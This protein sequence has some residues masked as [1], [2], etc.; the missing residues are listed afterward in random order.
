VSFRGFFYTYFSSDIHHD[1]PP[2]RLSALFEF[3]ILLLHELTHTFA[4]FVENAWPERPCEPRWAF[5]DVWQEH[6]YAYEQWFFHGRILSDVALYAKLATDASIFPA[7][8]LVLAQ[9]ML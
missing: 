3:T 5:E 4:F 2:G 9:T 6:G 7:D 8:V 1:T